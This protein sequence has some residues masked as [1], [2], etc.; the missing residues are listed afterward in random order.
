[1]TAWM[2]TADGRCAVSFHDA[3]NKEED[4]PGGVRLGE[5]LGEEPV[6]QLSGLRPITMTE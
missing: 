2:I 5:G 4:T 6:G 3:T 1:M